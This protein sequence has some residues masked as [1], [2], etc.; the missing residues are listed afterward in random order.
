MDKGEIIV[1]WKS[2]PKEQQSYIGCK[3]FYVDY[4]HAGRKDGSSNLPS[5]LTPCPSGTY[6]DDILPLSAC[7]SIPEGQGCISLSNND[8]NAGPFNGDQNSRVQYK[9][10]GSQNYYSYGTPVR[11]PGCSAVAVCSN[12]N[13]YF[14]EK[15]KTCIEPTRGTF[16]KNG[17]LQYCPLNTYNDKIEKVF[18][19][20]PKIPLGSQ[21]SGYTGTYYDNAVK[22]GCTGFVTCPANSEITGVSKCSCCPRSYELPSTA[23]RGVRSPDECVPIPAGR[24]SAL[25]ASS[26]SPP[27]PEAYRNCQ[28]DCPKGT[29]SVL[30]GG[31]DIESCKPAPMGS[32]V[33]Q[34]G[35][36]SYTP[37]P[38][39][40]YS[41]M[42]ATHT[43]YTF[44]NSRY[45]YNDD[46]YGR[47]Q[48]NHIYQEDHVVT[49]GATSAT[50][51]LPCHEGYYS[52]V[53][54]STACDII[55]A[56]GYS[57]NKRT[58][59]FC[60]IDTYSTMEGSMSAS[61]C[62]PCEQGF[63]TRS[64]GST[65]CEK[66][67]EEPNP[68]MGSSGAVSPNAA[69]P[70]TVYVL[71]SPRLVDLLGVAILSAIITIFLVKAFIN[72]AGI[73]L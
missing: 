11:L 24:Y 29:Y 45:D 13:R 40:T 53:V 6:N 18:D 4:S 17:M 38:A 31:L 15:N 57:L 2:T 70:S 22:P 50:D 33:D 61:T 42:V 36:S 52:S 26:T 25:C 21:C 43:T 47:K 46:D 1:N 8:N 35:S 59:E 37:C 65:A 39:S 64:V 10:M 44:T 30:E 58:L 55:P 23:I 32:F 71:T 63:F 5:Y 73:V 72:S 49:V 27:C 62:R 19:E 51:C 56:G 48:H 69:T 67:L 68:S 66:R 12:L 9:C 60:P 41:D 34:E 20:C 14:D 28:F 7:K 3:G 54:G 16:W